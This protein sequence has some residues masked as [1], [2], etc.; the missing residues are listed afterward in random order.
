MSERGSAGPVLGAFVIGAVAGAAVA[1][2]FAP[3][4]GEETRRKL[5]QKARE[6]RDKASAFA[7]D[8]RE[9]LQRQRDN[10][11]AAVERG[12]EVYEQVRKEP[13]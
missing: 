9:F 12:R 5:G 13:V 4:S 11:G 1:L 8:G 3:V 2:L 10:I 7:R 6:G